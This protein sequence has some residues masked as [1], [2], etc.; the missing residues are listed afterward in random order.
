MLIR[1]KRLQFLMKQSQARAMLE[2]ERSALRTGSAREAMVIPRRR[3]SIR[4]K[5]AVRRQINEKKKSRSAEKNEE[6]FYDAV[7]EA[8]DA[9]CATAALPTKQNTNDT[10]DQ[11]E[12]SGYGCFLSPYFMH[13][14]Q[15]EEDTSY[16][17]K[18][19][20]KNLSDQTL[21]LSSVT[22]FHVR[23]SIGKMTGLKIDENIKRMKDSKNRGITVGFVQIMGSGKYS[24]LS[25]PLL[26]DVEEA[27]ERTRSICWTHQLDGEESFKA[28]RCLHFSLSLKKEHGD[29]RSF[30]DNHD[31][32]DSSVDSYTPEVVKL[33]VGLKCG[34]ERLPLGIAKFVVNGTEVI[35]QHMDLTVLPVTD[36][37]AG[38]K[39]KRGV[40]G[41]KYRTSFK[42]GKFD[43][44]IARSAKLRIKADVK[45]GYPGQNG[46]EI[47]G[48]QDCSYAS[49]FDS[50]AIVASENSSSSK[51][52][53]A[54]PTIKVPSFKW[55]GRKRSFRKRS[56]KDSSSYDKDYYQDPNAPMRVIA[57]DGP[58]ELISAG[59]DISSRPGCA[60]AFACGPLLCL[61]FTTKSSTV[62]NHGYYNEDLATESEEMSESEIENLFEELRNMSSSGS[63][64]SSGESSSC[65]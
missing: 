53:L 43:F 25:K 64:C 23:L 45:V 38:Y 40:L 26:I 31:N 14:R 62:Q 18:A 57:L 58:G 59:S 8:R 35:D 46:E 54:F 28:R 16:R 50:N 51:N 21:R 32:D 60:K 10:S 5:L 55:K 13:E 39:S 22:S 49:V 37:A 3:D 30:E 47:W 65:E 44:S 1:I 4:R 33:L 61:G 27:T 11:R 24:A 48:D 19:D 41:K 17:A 12:E 56:G 52:G 63:T 34:D 36:P 29:C 42:N 20:S 9:P 15:N 2:E 7:Q 6:V